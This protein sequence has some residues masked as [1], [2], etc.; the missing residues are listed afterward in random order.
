VITTESQIPV[1]ARELFTLLDIL[2]RSSPVKYLSRTEVKVE[3]V[4][5]DT[6]DITGNTGQHLPIKIIRIIFRA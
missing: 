6:S 4:I 1:H 2:I 5:T 3:P